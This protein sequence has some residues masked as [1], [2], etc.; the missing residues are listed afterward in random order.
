MTKRK[1]L[2]RNAAIYDARMGGYSYTE[3]ARD[4][5]LGRTR[6]REIFI[7]QRYLRCAADPSMTPPDAASDTA[8]WV[9]LE[10]NRLAEIKRSA[11]R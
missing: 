7:W 4:F 8:L 3:I 9:L 2:D 1:Y 11:I 6:V 5:T 10:L